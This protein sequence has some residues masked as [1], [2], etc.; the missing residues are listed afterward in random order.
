MNR[1]LLGLLV[2]TLLVHVGT[3]SGIHLLLLQV[4]FLL[5]VLRFQ[6][7]VLRTAPQVVHLRNARL[8]AIA[9][10]ARVAHVAVGT[11]G[12]SGIRGAERQ[13][14]YCSGLA[15]LLADTGDGVADAF[16]L[17]RRFV[18]NDGGCRLDGL[19][20]R[21]MAKFGFDFEIERF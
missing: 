8:S 5:Q 12:I 16:S 6:F 9:A 17:C 13:C 4:Q 3:L 14:A 21:R 1:P 2:G 7:L 20:E 19:D 18:E 15:E 10:G 11:G